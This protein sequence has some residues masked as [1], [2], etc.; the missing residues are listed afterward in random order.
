METIQK[1]ALRLKTSRS[2][3]GPLGR[4][5]K[6][7]VAGESMRVHPY[8]N[9]VVLLWCRRTSDNSTNLRV[10]DYCRQIG[11]S[12]SI[13]TQLNNCHCVFGL[14]EDSVDLNFCE[15]SLVRVG[16]F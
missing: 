6:I 12:M 8:G 4:L 15:P 5:H 7:K 9:S 14:L 11:M 10:Q 2:P 13:V 16:F 3:L 1:R